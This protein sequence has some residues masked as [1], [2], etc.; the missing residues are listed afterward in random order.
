[1]I[2]SARRDNK[3]T[4]INKIIKILESWKLIDKKTLKQVKNKILSAYYSSLF[5]EK[6]ENNKY[7]LKELRKIN[8]K[9]SNTE[10]KLKE[11]KEKILYIK[12]WENT[13]FLWRNTMLNKKIV[14]DYKTTLAS[15]AKFG[16]TKKIF[17]NVI[18]KITN[19]NNGNN[20]NNANERKILMKNYKKLKQENTQLKIIRD[21]LIQKNE[22]NVIFIQNKRKQ[23][24]TLKD[25][26]NEKS[27]WWINKIL[28]WIDSVNI[29]ENDSQKEDLKNIIL[30]SYKNFKQNK[31]ED[32]IY[33]MA[34]SLE[35]YIDENFENIMKNLDWI[36]EKIDWL[37]LRKKKIR[38][39]E[40]S[41]K[42]EDIIPLKEE[43]YEIQLEITK[44]QKEYDE[45]KYN[46]E[47]KLKAYDWSTY[48]E[49]KAEFLNNNKK[50]GG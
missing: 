49:K 9:I 43:E 24:N 44:L 1:M 2:I 10:K 8:T 33:K 6:K 23:C 48:E 15:K 21:E 7:N 27:E 22:D 18:G 34:K 45:I 12:L 11:I 13:K 5:D 46:I 19:I 17:G 41:W 32:D 3:K 20:A 35:S 26:I 4:E 28:N 30:E 37:E 31:N 40:Q 25:Y 39:K 38:E 14:K 36:Q 50:N 16:F 29:R 42:I 47:E